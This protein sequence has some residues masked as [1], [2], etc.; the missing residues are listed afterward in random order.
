VLADLVLA[1]ILQQGT[2]RRE[3]GVAVQLRRRAGIVVRQRHV[4]GALRFDRE[5]HAD[6][7]RAHRIE[8]VRFR[9]ERDQVGVAQFRQ[10]VFDA[11]ARSA[12]SYRPWRKPSPSREE[13]GV[14]M[15]FNKGLRAEG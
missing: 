2:Q 1:R 3:H 13:V 7:L 15:V 5:R 12:G 11:R 10:P 9:V 6:D 8:A 14:G 4:G